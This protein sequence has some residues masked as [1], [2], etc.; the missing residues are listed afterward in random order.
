MPCPKRSSWDAQLPVLLLAKLLGALGDVDL[1]GV[2]GMLAGEML[3]L[4]MMR[5]VA[6]AD[7]EADAD[8]DAEADADADAEADVSHACEMVRTECGVNNMH[9]AVMYQSSGRVRR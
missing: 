1:W 7:A 2:G 9:P 8:A 4:T 5:E 3:M 6:D